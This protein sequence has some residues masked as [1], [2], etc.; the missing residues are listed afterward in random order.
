M[1]K[2]SQRRFYALDCSDDTRLSPV[3]SNLVQ[4]EINDA[5]KEFPV[6]LLFSTYS[7][8][9]ERIR[10]T[11][12][13]SYKVLTFAP[14]LKYDVCPL[15]AL[16]SHLLALA[17]EGMGC[18]VEVEFAVDVQP[19]PANNVLYLLQVRPIVTGSE[20]NSQ[21]LL[22]LSAVIPYSG[23]KDPLAKAFIM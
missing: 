21:P 14:F 3:N 15:P 8:Q 6:R 16:L 10:D 12:L 7:A 20:K 19:D 13:P 5:V 23:R 9:E 4:R 17:R 11:D 2:N 18:E 1:L 22:I